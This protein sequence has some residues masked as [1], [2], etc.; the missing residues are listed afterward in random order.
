MAAPAILARGILQSPHGDK[1]RVRQETVA[2]QTHLG[3]LYLMPIRYFPFPDPSS[4]LS[5]AKKL[6][7]FW[8][9]IEPAVP[10][11]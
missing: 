10:I 1:K 3:I 11:K 2:Q 5:P 8:H 9:S 7:G 4:H 6:R